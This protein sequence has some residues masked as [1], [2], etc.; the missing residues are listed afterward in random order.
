MG[1]LHHW[2]DVLFHDFGGQFWV[3]LLLRQ[4][5]EQVVRGRSR[6]FEA[7]VVGTVRLLRDHVVGILEGCQIRRDWAH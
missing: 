7:F 3:Q 4:R 1:L 5:V 6:A 2:D